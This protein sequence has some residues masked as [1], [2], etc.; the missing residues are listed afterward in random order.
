ML[1]NVRIASF[2]ALFGITD[3]PYWVSVIFTISIF[4]QFSFSL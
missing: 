3:L 2:Y 1:G 4:L